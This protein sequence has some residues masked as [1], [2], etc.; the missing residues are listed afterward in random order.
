[1]RHAERRIRKEKREKKVLYRYINCALKECRYI[2]YES[3]W[4]HQVIWLLPSS[5]SPRTFRSALTLYSSSKITSVLNPLARD[6]LGLHLTSP[7][8]T[9]SWSSPFISPLCSSAAVSM[10]LLCVCM[11]SLASSPLDG[12]RTR[13]L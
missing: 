1:M 6:S 13:V 4:R 8:A 10:S 2:V 7:R 12:L 11:A 9:N 3:Q 5:L